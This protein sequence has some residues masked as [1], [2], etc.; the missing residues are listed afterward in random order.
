MQNTTLIAALKTLSPTDWRSLSDLVRSPFFQKRKDV[1]KLFAYLEKQLQNP[2]PPVRFLE[3]ENVWKAVFPAEKYDE[4][5]LRYQMSWLLDAFRAWLTQAELAADEAQSQLYLT[6]ALRKRGLDDLFEK[7][8]KKTAQLIENQPFRDARHHYLRYRLQHENLEKASSQR[9]GGTLALQ[10]LS[11]ELA[12]FFASETLRQACTAASHEATSGHATDI[13]SL[14]DV[15]RQVEAEGILRYPA[16]AVYYHAFKALSSTQNPKLDPEASGQNF[17][18]EALKTLVETHWQAFSPAE[19]RGIYLLSINF[20]IQRLNSGDRAFV[21]E[22]FEL[23]RAA[24]GRGLLLENGVLTPFTYK[25]ILRLGLSLGETDWSRRFLDEQKRFL[26]AR[27]R[28]NTGRYNLAFFFFQQKNYAEAMPLL[29]KTDPG[30]VLNNLDARRMLLR[31]YVELGERQALESLLDAF[32][33]YL[34][35]Q[36]DLG[37]GR[38]NYLKLIHFVKKWQALAPENTAANARLR[39]Q[40]EAATAV[41]DR[42]W[43]LEKV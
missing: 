16:V 33:I 30:D 20:C 17:H 41:A 1:E 43:L 37:Y 11:D 14:A 32:E 42:E 6:H 3:K 25:N 18:F 34:R 7:E 19:M 10:P 13:R 12:V 15:L 39:R 8:S 2:R 35:R 22:A 36:K 9:R 4:K 29:Q 28:E 5:Q 38:E 26:P 24:L 31:I 21:R 40:I 23:Y 27:E